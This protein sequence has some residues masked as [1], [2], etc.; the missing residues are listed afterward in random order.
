MSC[1]NVEN[2]KTQ[3]TWLTASSAFRRNSEIFSSVCLLMSPMI[4]TSWCDICPVVLSLPRCCRIDMAFLVFSTIPLMHDNI[5][6]IFFHSSSPLEIPDP[7]TWLAV[8][9]G[10]VTL[11]RL[12]RFDSDLISRSSRDDVL[13]CVYIMILRSNSIKRLNKNW[14]NRS[15]TYHLFLMCVNTVLILEKRWMIY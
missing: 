2:S 7:F 5:V 15:E 10:F 11:I 13:C 6:W 1:F 8:A 4:E 3:L 9:V 14:M 12:E